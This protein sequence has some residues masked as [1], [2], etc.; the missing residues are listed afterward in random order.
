MKGMD[1]L[2]SCPGRVQVI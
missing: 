2:T 1:S